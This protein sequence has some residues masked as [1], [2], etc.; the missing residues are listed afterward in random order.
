[1]EAKEVQNE[2]SMLGTIQKQEIVQDLVNDLENTPSNCRGDTKN[3]H[4]NDTAHLE[5]ETRVS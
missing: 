4:D 2:G 5:P 1:M 3:K